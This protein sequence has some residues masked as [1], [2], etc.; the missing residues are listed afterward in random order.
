LLNGDG[1]PKENRKDGLKYIGIRQ[2]EEKAAS[3]GE[4]GGK[5]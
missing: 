1:L 2:S 5:F 4:G 3:R